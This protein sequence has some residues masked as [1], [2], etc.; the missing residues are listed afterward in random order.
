LTPEVEDDLYLEVKIGEISFCSRLNVGSLSTRVANVVDVG[1]VG[2]GSSVSAALDVR[3]GLKERK[4][5]L[6]L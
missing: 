5:F 4:R 6:K 3:D 2:E 1:D